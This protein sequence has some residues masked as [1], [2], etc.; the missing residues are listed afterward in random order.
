MA[1]G[2][3][4]KIRPDSILMKYIQSVKQTT[5]SSS[6]SGSNI[7][8]V[9]DSDGETNEINIKNGSKGSTGL[10]GDTGELGPTGPQGERGSVGPQGAVG[11]SGPVGPTGPQ[12]N[13]GIQGLIG[14]TGPQGKQGIQG[15]TGSV[16][17]TG[18]QGKAGENGSAG[19]TGPTGPQGKQ[20]IQGDTGNAGPTGPIGLTGN[21]GPTG[22]TGLVGPT[23]PQGK[24]GGGGSIGPTGATG[25]TGPQGKQGSLGPTGPQGKQGENG[26]I[27]A[28]GSVGPTGPK[29]A[30]GLVGPTGPHGER[31]E[32]GATGIS[33]VY[34]SDEWIDLS[35]LDQ[36][37]YFPVIG[38]IMPIDRI[39]IFECFV[40][41]DSKT[42]PSWSTHTSGFAVNYKIAILPNGWGVFPENKN[43][44]ILESDICHWC[45]GTSP[46]SFTEMWHSKTPVFW[47]RG[48]GRYRLRT[49]YKINWEIKTSGYTKWEETVAPQS[50]RPN[51]QYTFAHI[52]SNEYKTAMDD[53]AAYPFSQLGANT[54]YKDIE[55]V[56]EYNRTF[57]CKYYAT[58]QALLDSIANHEYP[59][60]GNTAAGVVSIN[61]GWFHLLYMGTQQ[62]ISVMI[63]HYSDT[64][65]HYW[66]DNSSEWHSRNLVTPNWSDILGKP[67]TF[68]PDGIGTISIDSY[69]RFKGSMNGTP[70]VI[71]RSTY[72]SGGVVSLQMRH[73]GT[74]WILEVCSI[75][76]GEKYH[77][78]FIPDSGLQSGW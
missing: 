8:T 6:D 35:S 40:F 67:S 39:S 58:T 31:G 64:V 41:L 69:T 24:T 50:S 34:V 23:G 78:H 14:P 54:M 17:P 53:G 21:I 49:T 68:T 72:D 47:C 63:F 57:T 42:V 28:T 70:V 38:D 77:M 76:N 18:P 73:N 12:G 19:A 11:A 44:F 33:D 74:Q 20:G 29:G 7:I 66:H 37:T 4:I 71:P 32:M 30:Q 62:Y 59:F 56:N 22:P 9:T 43:T 45:N 60:D 46:I 5:E 27:G 15:D 48:G 2:D 52:T 13:Q 3:K 65:M 10:Q 55:N 36:N 26:S 1:F 25:P 75:I 61:G 51:P 16:G